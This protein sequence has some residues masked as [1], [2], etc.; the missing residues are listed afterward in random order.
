MFPYSCRPCICCPPSNAVTRSYSGSGSIAY[1]CPSSVNAYASHRV[2][3]MG[4]VDAPATS[5][6]LAGCFL[7]VAYVCYMVNITIGNVIEFETQL[8]YCRPAPL[9]HI[10]I[11]RILVLCHED[12]NDNDCHS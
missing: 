5:L 4:P 11:S 7:Q 9:P 3:V 10:L 6:H 2:V 8:Y 1:S 12:S